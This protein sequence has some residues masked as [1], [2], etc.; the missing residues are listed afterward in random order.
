MQQEIGES[1]AEAEDDCPSTIEAVPP[2]P[3]VLRM[4]KMPNAK[5]QPLPK[6]QAVAK[7][8]IV[9]KSTT[10]KRGRRCSIVQKRSWA[11][12]EASGISTAAIVKR[13]LL[14]STHFV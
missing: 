4:L 13:L 9:A 6:T 5:R 12:I 2:T 14:S 3:T 1:D 8:K 10:K 7:S 11:A